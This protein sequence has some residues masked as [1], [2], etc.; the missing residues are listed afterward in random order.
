ML[1][2]FVLKVIDR[3]KTSCKFAQFSIRQICVSKCGIQDKCGAMIR[4]FKLTGGDW[5]NKAIC[6]IGIITKWV[7][8][9]NKFFLPGNLRRGSYLV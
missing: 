8:Y 6:Q 2:V 1:Q 5:L 9:I 3:K 4:K 7:S